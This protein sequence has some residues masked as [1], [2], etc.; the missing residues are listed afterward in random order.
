MNRKKRSGFTLLEILICF[1]GLSVVMTVIISASHRVRDHAH[2]TLCM[3]NLRQISFAVSQYYNDY[4]EYPRGLPYDTLSN[5]LD[6]YIGKAVFICPEDRM[7]QS[8]SY[9]QYYVYRGNDVS[10]FQYV[11]GCPRHASRSKSVNIFSLQKA[12]T[13]QN[14]KVISNETEILPGSYTTGTITLEDGSTIQSDSM[15]MIVLQSVRLGSGALY[16]VVRVPE[17]QS[18]SLTVNATPG[19]KLEIVT[20]AVVAGVRGTRFVL[21]IGYE[22]DLPYTNVSV[23]EGVVAVEPLGGDN[24]DGT[25]EKAAGFSPIL[26]TKN[27]AVK[28]RSRSRPFA[29]DA[30][31]DRIEGLHKKIALYDAAGRDSNN[32]REMSEWLETTT[33]WA[34]ETNA[35][36]TAVDRAN[37]NASFK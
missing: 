27:M 8:D 6:S 28:I 16:T 9:S 25:S 1:A 12:Q 5:Q 32:I 31:S 30:L 19:T 11:I 7:E 22:E 17:N 10:S 37:E 2:S 23:E 18:G 20:P 15:K 35:N 13:F 3:N 33:A 24:I 21:D 14:A 4:K 29:L 36:E 34:I 26:L